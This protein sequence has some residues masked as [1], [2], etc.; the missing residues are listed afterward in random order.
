MEVFGKMRAPV[1]VVDEH[2]QFCHLLLLP[3]G[4]PKKQKILG[5]GKF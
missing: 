1:K 4:D 2:P 3:L 5:A